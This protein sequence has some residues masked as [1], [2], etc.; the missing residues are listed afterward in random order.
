MIKALL[1][2][3]MIAVSGCAGTLGAVSALS[4]AAVPKVSAHIGDNETKVGE[5]QVGSKTES[6]SKVEKIKAKESKVDQSTKKEDKK[7]EVGTVQGDLKVNQGPSA[8]TLA[9]LGAGWPLFMVFLVWVAL[10]RA[11]NVNITGSGETT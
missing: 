7:T 10:R 3:A 8:L 4:S 5:A 1:L 9:F 11:K 2:A 6:Q